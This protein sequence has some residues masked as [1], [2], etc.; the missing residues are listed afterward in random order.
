MNG[1]TRIWW[2]PIFWIMGTSAMAEPAACSEPPVEYQLG[3]K[4]YVVKPLQEF[5]EDLPKPPA[6]KQSEA[7]W[8][9]W[10]DTFFLYALGPQWNTDF[11]LPEAEKKTWQIRGISLHP[12]TWWWNS[13]VGPT[14]TLL[15]ERP[16]TR[17]WNRMETI[18]FVPERGIFEP[19][20]ELVS[21][22]L[23]AKTSRE[24]ISLMWQRWYNYRWRA[25]GGAYMACLPKGK[26][27]LSSMREGIFFFEDFIAEGVFH[28]IGMKVCTNFSDQKWRRG[29]EKTQPPISLMVFVFLREYLLQPFPQLYI[30][31]PL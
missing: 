13:S 11:G 19:N 26:D 23:G 22:L 17:K 16:L 4:Q 5:L 18:P 31:T 2:Q 28:N 7:E 21:I 30:K 25:R 29:E 24:S 1:M 9:E 10:S 15:F 27:L 6:V 12:P 8:E 14:G 20:L 3:G